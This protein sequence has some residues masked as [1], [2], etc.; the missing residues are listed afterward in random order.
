MRGFDSCY[1]CILNVGAYKNLKRLVTKLT[2]TR[3]KNKS[4]LAPLRQK[5]KAKS[6]LRRRLRIT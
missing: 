1:P 5:N 2:P 3:Q 4:K 6:I